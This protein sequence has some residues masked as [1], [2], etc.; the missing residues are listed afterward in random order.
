MSGSV[1]T[2]AVVLRSMRFGEADRILH[3]YT[4]HRGS[5]RRDREGRAARAQPLR[6]APGAVLSPAY[7]PLR[8]QERP[9]DRHERRD[10]Q[11]SSAAA[12][13]RRGARFGGP[14][15]RRGVAPV[16]HARAA[17]RRVRAPLQRARAA[18]RAAGAGDARQPARVSPQA[19]ARRGARAAARRV[20]RLRRG[21]PP[22][23]V[24]GRGGRRRLRRVRGVGLSARP[25]G[26]RLPH[27]RARLSARRRRRARAS[28]HCAKRTARSPRRSSTTPTFDSDPPFRDRIRPW[29]RARSPSS[30]S[31]TSRRDRA[32]CATSSAARARTS[33]R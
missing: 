26:A 13:A 21:R 33:P 5:G 15:V 14:R 17:S 11:R 32:R 1:K 7:G 10:R 31:T 3:L 12:R 16:R 4:P 23:V 18:R 2:E 28:S 25:G 22:D 8:R 19:P 20:R 27:R 24:L 29:E 6:R 9:H 30:G